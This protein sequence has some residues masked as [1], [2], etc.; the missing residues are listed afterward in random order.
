MIKVF[1]QNHFE[2]NCSLI[3][4]QTKE[5]VLVDVCSQKDSERQEILDFINKNELRV[6]HILLTHPHIDHVCGALWASETFNLPLELHKDGEE[7]LS[8]AEVQAQMMGFNVE[9]IDNLK[10]KYISKSDKI[11]FG[12]SEL[13]V[14]ET[15]GHCAGSLS[16]YN[17]KEGFVITGDALFQGSIGRTDLPTGDFDLLSK[18]IKENLF[19]L[20]ENTECICGHGPNTTIGFEKENNPFLN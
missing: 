17:E 1:A 7:I 19:T 15:P 11:S 14:I 18:S 2:V 9:G 6:K 20:P 16:F 12:D 10:K 3:Y 13:R 8:M 4:D 5:C